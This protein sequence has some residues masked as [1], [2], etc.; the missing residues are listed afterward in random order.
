MGTDNVKE[1]K[2]DT[3][4]P[5][6]DSME[7]ELLENKK[8]KEAGSDGSAKW[9]N[10]DELVGEPPKM[11]K[12]DNLAFWKGLFIGLAIEAAGIALI[13]LLIRLF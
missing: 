3:S 9:K 6:E 7:E 8:M 11:E 2:V 10:I 13:V 1:I 4:I 5:E 12:V